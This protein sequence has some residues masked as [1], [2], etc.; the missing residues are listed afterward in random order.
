MLLAGSCSPVILAVSIINSLTLSL[1]AQ[2]LP[3]PAILP[4][5]DSLSASRT[6][7]TDYYRHG[8]VSPELFCFFF[9]FLIIISLRRR[10]L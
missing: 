8:T 2:N 3:V 5:T 1:P 10:S 7:F 9:R 6:D 4:S